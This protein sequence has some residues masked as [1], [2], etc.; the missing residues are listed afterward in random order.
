MVRHVFLDSLPFH[1]I[2][3]KHGSNQ[4][5]LDS[6]KRHG[7]PCAE[8]SERVCSERNRDFASNQEAHH[9]VHEGQEDN[10][11]QCVGES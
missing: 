7:P 4:N 5:G 1:P 9:S 6:N 10:S 3:T 11:F 8:R 2:E